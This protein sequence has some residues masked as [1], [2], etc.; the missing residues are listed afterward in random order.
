KN[1][2]YFQLND[3]VMDLITAI[4]SP[5]RESAEDDNE[6]EALRFSTP[7]AVFESMQDAFN[8]DAAA[9]QDVIFQYIISGEEGGNWFCIVKDSSCT[10]KA[11]QHD[12]PTCTLKINSKNFLAMMNGIIT[13]MQAYSSGKLG[14]EGDIMK[15]QLIEKLFNL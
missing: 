1:K 12:K 15:S 8:A 13:P 6:N 4:D 7:A 10:I 5:P 3:Q 14:I 9:G 11:Q 2:E